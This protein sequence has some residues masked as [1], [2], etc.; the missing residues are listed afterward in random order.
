MSK[1]N[2]YYRYLP[3]SPRDREWGLFVTGAG[4]R[5]VPPNSPYPRREHI[6]PPSHEYSWQCG[7]RFHEYAIVY[8]SDGRGEFESKQS[9]RTAFGPGT[10]LLLFPEVWHRYRPVREIGWREYWV[11]FH[12]DIADRLQQNGFIKPETPVVNTGLDDG[13]IRS[14]QAI[15]DR[16]RSEMVGF[17][18]LIAAETLAIIAGVLAAERNRWADSR[19]CELVRRAK[20]V[21]EE[22][23]DDLPVIENLADSLGVSAGH[24]RRI[25]KQYTGLSPYQYHLQLKI[26]RAKLMLRESDMPIKHIASQL[27]FR[28]VYH[29]SKLFKKLAEAP[30]NRWRSGSQKANSAGRLP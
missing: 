24:L 16:L 19:R 2:E 9:G 21:I 15:L 27:G 1:T 12:G 5:D 25:F 11:T 28:N 4:Y 18:Q 20:A 6:H 13:I 30:P 7:R 26:G 17:Q 8:L 23:S 3:T 14:F 29:F 22:Q 10:T